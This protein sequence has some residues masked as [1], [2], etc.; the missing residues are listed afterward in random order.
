MCALVQAIRKLGIVAGG[1]GIGEATNPMHIIR[2]T[3]DPPH[4]NSSDYT[5]G[6]RP[7]TSGTTSSDFDSS[8]GQ[9]RRMAEDPSTRIDDYRQRQQPQQQQQ[10]HIFEYYTEDD[11]DRQLS[12]RT[13]VGGG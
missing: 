4:F 3:P 8:F 5:N 2:T 1:P 10:Q 7:G 6:S 13:E 9:R 12:G 11:L